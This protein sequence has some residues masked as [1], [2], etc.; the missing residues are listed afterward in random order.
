MRG[1]SFFLL[2]FLLLP[3]PAKADLKLCNRTS[4]VLEAATST[5]IKNT[6]SLTQGWLHIFPGDCALAVK[7]SRTFSTSIAALRK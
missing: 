7:G 5:I 6:E 3:H 4:Y 1:A 2:I